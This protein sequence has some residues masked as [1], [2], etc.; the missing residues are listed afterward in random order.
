MQ[1]KFW[2]QSTWVS[3]LTASLIKIVDHQF[4]N[5]LLNFLNFIL[6]LT[7]LFFSVRMKSAQPGTCFPWSLAVPLAA[8]L[9]LKGR[10]FVADNKFRND[11]ADAI[12]LYFMELVL[13]G[14]DF[15]DIF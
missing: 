13:Y 6:F 11:L 4:F 3:I 12:R 14:I 10:F 7:F 1:Q 9:S 8:I 5:K 2:P 15:A